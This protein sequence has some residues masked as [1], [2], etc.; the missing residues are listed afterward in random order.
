MVTG[1]SELERVS[2][3]RLEDT[4]HPTG[5]GSMLPF[6][7]CGR[8]LAEA[9]T[10]NALAVECNRAAFERVM[11]RPP[12]NDQEANDL[13]MS[14]VQQCRCDPEDRSV[15]PWVKTEKQITSNS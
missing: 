6:Y 2:A 8:N 10:W 5:N 3:T 14:L 13:I 11:G 7:E 1:I 9:D 4:E 12:V 15:C